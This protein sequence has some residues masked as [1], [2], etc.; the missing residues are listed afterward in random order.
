MWHGDGLTLAGFAVAAQT[1]TGAAAA[2]A[3]L[4]AVPQQAHVRAAAGLPMLVGGTRVT[5]H[6]Q[7]RAPQRQGRG[8]SD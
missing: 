8:I 1:E 7:Q 4:V 5:P 2:G 3:R 6:C